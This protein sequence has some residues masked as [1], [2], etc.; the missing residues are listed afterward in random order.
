LQW[1]AIQSEPVIEQEKSMRRGNRFHQMIQQNFLGLSGEQIVEQ[2]DDPDLARW[3]QNFHQFLSKTDLPTIRN[4]EYGISGSINGFRAVAKFDLLAVEPGKRAFIF[5]WKTSK[6]KSPVWI[7]TERIQ[8]RLYP[9]LF[10]EAVNR[11]VLGSK[12]LPDQ[13]EMIYWFA[14]DPV[15]PVRF[16]YSYARFETDRTFLKN[17][18]DEINNHTPGSFLLT[19]DEKKCTFCVY[20]SLCNRGVSAGIGTD[21]EDQ[22]L[23]QDPVQ[24]IDLNF[25]QI[26]E[27]E[28]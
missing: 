9:F 7:L 21:D 11:I 13:L 2:T 14:E 28:F 22:N 5:D 24:T 4:P 15:Q 17:L 20:R 3:W 19:P 18:V 12:I 1:P 16:P 6:K 25:D 26:G 27:I 23:E 8:T 10:I